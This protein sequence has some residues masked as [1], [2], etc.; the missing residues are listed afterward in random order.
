MQVSVNV[1]GAQDIRPVR[2]VVSPMVCPGS[3]YAA[4]VFACDEVIPYRYHVPDSSAIR[5]VPRM[6]PLY[7]LI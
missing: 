7:R 6:T 3:R 5:G 2:T 4:A 1:S